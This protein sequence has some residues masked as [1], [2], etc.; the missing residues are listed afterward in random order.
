MFEF[1]KNL[2]LVRENRIY[3]YEQGLEIAKL[4]NLEYPIVKTPN[5]QQLVNETEATFYKG[6]KVLEQNLVQLKKLLQKL[7]ID[8]F[9]HDLIIDK[10]SPP[11]D[12]TKTNIL[13]IFISFIFG[14]LISLIVVF[15]K[16]Q[17]RIK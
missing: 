8:Q 13:T 4:I 14:F 16:S 1:K 7:E 17:I 2:K 9:N 15:L 3:Y 5:N 6:S 10:A 12:Y 11:S